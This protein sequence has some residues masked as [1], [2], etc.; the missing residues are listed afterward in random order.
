MELL[1]DPASLALG[2]GVNSSISANL[3]M[4]STEPPDSSRWDLMFPTI[5]LH[6]TCLSETAALYENIKKIRMVQVFGH[7][8]PS[9]PTLCR[10]Q[11]SEARRQVRSER[12]RWMLP[13]PRSLAVSALVRNPDF[14]EPYLHQLKQ[15]PRVDEHALSSPR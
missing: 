12:A 6:N 4:I 8:F 14:I 13:I 7:L 15:T 1:T 5:G 3:L 10:Y 2:P 9:C 11:Q